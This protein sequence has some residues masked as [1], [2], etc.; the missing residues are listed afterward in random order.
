ME[1]GG[2]LSSAQISIYVD[3]SVYLCIGPCCCNT[4]RFCCPLQGRALDHVLVGFG[5]GRSGLAQKG[6]RANDARRNH[7]VVGSLRV[8]QRILAVTP[9]DRIQPHWRR[10]CGQENR[11]LRA[12]FGR[13]RNMTEP[14]Y[15]S[16]GMSPVLRKGSA[17][18]FMGGRDIW[19]GRRPG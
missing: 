14:W 1:V 18:L 13:P 15:I 4:D 19:P 17:R 8:D 12:I 10:V 3:L 5:H 6:S 16:G 2:V 7:A 9:L 11:W